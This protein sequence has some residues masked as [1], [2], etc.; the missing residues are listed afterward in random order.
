MAK[1]TKCPESRFHSPHAIDVEED[2]EQRPLAVKLN[3]ANLGIASVD[4]RW[5]EEEPETEWR[6]SPMTMMYYL[7]TLEDSQQL[8]LIRNMTYERWYYQAAQIR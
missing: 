3:G 6:D 7:V 5:E 8:T 4:E 2:S 1:N